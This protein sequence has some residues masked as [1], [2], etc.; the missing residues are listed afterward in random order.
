MTVVLKLVCGWIGAALALFFFISPIVPFIKLIKHQVKLNTIPIIM[1]I[2]SVLNCVFWFSYG[3]YINEYPVWV[4]NGVGALISSIWII[5][6]WVFFAELKWIP[7]IIYNLIYINII[8]ELYYIIHIIVGRE[9]N[10]VIGWIAMGVNILMYAAPGAKV[11]Q[12]FKTSNLD[13][14]PIYSSI[15]CV[16]NSTF[17][18]I[19]GLTI[20]DFTIIVP[21]VLGV[22]FAILQIIAW[23]VVKKRLNDQERRKAAAEC[24]KIELGICPT[25]TNENL[26]KDN[27]V[28]N[29]SFRNSSLTSKHVNENEHISVIVI[30]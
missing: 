2:C 18:F 25:G 6:Y 23:L 4:C 14:L 1:L 20:S 3:L 9:G 28:P 8:G 7:A 11:I 29:N 30:S 15:C 13:L 24:A 19:Y 5:I 16:V 27:I 17:W 22:A 26:K 10:S 12:L 21:N